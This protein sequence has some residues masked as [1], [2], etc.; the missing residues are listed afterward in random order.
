MEPPILS[1][2]TGT[3][4]RRDAFNRLVRSII[5]RTDMPWELVVSDASDEPYPDEYPD[6]VKIIPE[7]P[8]LGCVKGYN[9][10]FS[11]CS[12][13][14]VLYLNDDAEVMPG[15]ARAA[16]DYM[17]ANPEIGLGALYYA[18]V[19]LP[20]A[21][22]EYKDMVYANFGILS[23]ELGN[24][25]GWMDTITKMYGND[26]SIAFRVLMEGKGIGTIEKARI[27]HHSVNDKLRQENQEGRFE[28]ASKLMEKYGPFLGTMLRTYREKSK[29]GRL[30]LNEVY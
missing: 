25:I 21:V 5:S 23:K 27:W 29:I 1:L 28:D 19:T 24:K 3:L 9:K 10:A 26:N 20:F 18:E 11:M 8:R 6:N 22:Q 16:V 4:N 2:V 7:R 15:Y 17:E 14:W 30:V 12:G 13:K